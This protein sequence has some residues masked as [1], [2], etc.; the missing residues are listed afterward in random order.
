M[1]NTLLIVAL[2]ERQLPV[3]AMS[4]VPDLHSQR[5][6]PTLHPPQ[7]QGHHRPPPEGGRRE[8]GAAAYRPPGTGCC[9][10]ATCDQE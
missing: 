4:A 10:S 5:P 1:E 2:M 9:P 6:S 7:S 3:G 8:G